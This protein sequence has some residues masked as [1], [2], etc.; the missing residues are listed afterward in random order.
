VVLTNV[1]FVTSQQFAGHQVALTTLTYSQR[2]SLST[3]FCIVSRVDHPFSCSYGPQF[4]LL[5]KCAAWL[6]DAQKFLEHEMQRP[7]TSES[8]MMT[9]NHRSQY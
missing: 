5:E 6:P 9:V 4:Q 8:V 7:G 3:L 1:L 2:H